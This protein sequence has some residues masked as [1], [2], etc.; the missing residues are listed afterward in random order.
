MTEMVHGQ[1]GLAA[2]E[3]IS[4][5]LFRNNLGQLDESDLEQLALDGMD[6]TRLPESTLVEALV[7]SG[8]AVTPRGEVTA[9]QARKL[10]QG[11][12]VSVNGEKIGDVESRITKENALFGRFFIIQKGKRNH[13]LIEL[14]GSA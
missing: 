13:H 12:G 11:N 8:L 9:G 2:A 10:I 6:T 1:E 4:E 3:R 14:E 7:E 5:S